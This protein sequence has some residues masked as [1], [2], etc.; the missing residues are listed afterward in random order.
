MHPVS[1]AILAQGGGLSMKWRIRPRAPPPPGLKG[2]GNTPPPGMATASSAMGIDLHP[3]AAAAPPVS[4]SPQSAAA[5]AP[6]TV[7]LDLC[8]PGPSGGGA[9]RAFMPW[10]DARIPAL[11]GSCPSR[12]DRG[13]ARGSGCRI[14][15]E[16]ALEHLGGPRVREAVLPREP[17]SLRRPGAGGQP[18]AVRGAGEPVEGSRQRELAAVR[19]PDGLEG[20]EPPGERPRR[21]RPPVPGRG[22]QVIAAQGAGDV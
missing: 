2:D 5:V 9:L 16:H 21:L 4:A 12:R 8:S 14:R 1:S 20:R 22:R 15:P 19:G 10:E 11:T 6:D 18:G 17:R 7:M 3:G 13:G